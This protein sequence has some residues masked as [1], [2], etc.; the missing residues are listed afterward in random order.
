MVSIMWIVFQ[1]SPLTNWYLP[2]SVNLARSE[3]EEQ[4]RKYAGVRELAIGEIKE[5]EVYIPAT[6]QES[7]RKERV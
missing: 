7:W 3:A 5:I 4:V 1:L 6:K 2:Y